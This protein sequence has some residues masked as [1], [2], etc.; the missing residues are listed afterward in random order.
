MHKVLIVATSRKTRGGITSVIKAHE[1]GE[2]WKRFHCH[3]VQTHRDGPNWRKV[4]YFVHGFID[5]LIRVAW[6]DIVHIHISQP[7]SIK[8]KTI[9]FKIAKIF[10]K[11]IL[12]HFHAFNTKDTISGNYA[13]LYDYFFKNSDKVIVLSNWW[14]EELIK[15]LSTPSEKIEVLYNPCPITK[16]KES[17]KTNSILYAGTVNERK[18]YADLIKAFAKIADKNPSWVLNIAGNGEIKQGKELAEK[19]NITERVNFLGWIDGKAKE[20][21]FLEASIFCLPSYA[22]GFPM[23]V[24]DA[25][26]YGIP[27][28]ATPVGGIPDVAVNGENMLLFNPGDINSLASQLDKLI[29]DSNLRSR[30]SQHSIGFAK[31]DFNIST[32]NTRLGEIYKGLE[33]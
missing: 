10:R 29:N 31:D 28:I 30:L 2:Q 17:R 27:V 8:R 13:R 24:L 20:T 19:L 7:T 11:K 1:T 25:W 22:E 21:A 33:E 9:F 6:T 12:V 32:I 3:W 16:Q 5:F 14:K 15:T 23:A 18:G 4:L 26:A